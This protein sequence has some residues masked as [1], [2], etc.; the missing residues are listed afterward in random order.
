MRVGLAELDV[1]DRND[2]VGRDHSSRP[3]PR[4][5]ERPRARGHDRLAVGVNRDEGGFGSRQHRDAVDVVGF[6]LL[7]PGVRL[8]ELLLAHEGGNEIARWLSATA[9]PERLLDPV[10]AGLL[11]PRALHRGGRVDE[12]AVHVEEDSVEGSTEDGVGGEVSHP[13]SGPAARGP[14][15]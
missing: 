12:G 14:A 13:S 1:V 11:E 5:R 2:E 15:G 6:N 3:D 9:V 7:D 4:R 8:S 10:F